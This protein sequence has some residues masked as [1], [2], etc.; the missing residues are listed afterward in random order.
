[1]SLLIQVYIII[2]F[3]FKV[4]TFMPFIDGF[5]SHNIGSQS[6]TLIKL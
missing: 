5:K 1:M 2:R 4:H 3:T 6:R